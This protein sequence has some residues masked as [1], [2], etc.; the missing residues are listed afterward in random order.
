[1]RWNTVFRKD[2]NEE[3]VGKSPGVNVNVTGDEDDLF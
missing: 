3:K 2:V 1:M